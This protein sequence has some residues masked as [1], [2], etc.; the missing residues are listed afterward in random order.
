MAATITKLTTKRQKFR[1]DQAALLREALLPF[2]A[3]LP[4]QVRDVIGYID[5]QTASANRWT[6]VMLSPAQNDAVVNYL[7]EHSKRPLVAVR[8]WSLCFKHFRS[9]TGEILLTREEFA[10]KLGTTAPHISEIM[11]ELVKIKAIITHRERVRGM[12]GPGMVRYF[13]N[14][15]V[16]TNL[17]GAARDEAQAKAPPLLTLMHGGAE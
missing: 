8:L 7:V 5:Q 17:G 4:E 9:D 14:P 2:E 16:A 15:N 10:E 6:F 1:A 11:G 12:R 3:E 13:M